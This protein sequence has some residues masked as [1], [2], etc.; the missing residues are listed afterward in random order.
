V[1][2]DLVTGLGRQWFL[3]NLVGFAVGGGIFGASQARWL[4]P[5]FEVVTDPATA[6]RIQALSSGIGVTLFGASV[7]FAEWL[8][9]RRRVPAAWW[10]PAT[11]LGFGLA[12]A[13]AGALSGLLGGTVTGMGPEHGIAGFVAAVIV[14][15]LALGLLPG[16]L[17]WM[18]LRRSSRRAGR[19]PWVTL[20]ALLAG[21]FGA[22]VI[23]RLG[24]A[25]VIRWLQPEDFPSA[26]ALTCA[27]LVIG[28]VYAV[29]TLSSLRRALKPAIPEPEA[30]VSRDVDQS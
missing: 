14:S 6:A 27:G 28:G 12:G 5:Y 9:L 10:A 19:W 11:M 3:A 18:I 26:K 20:A 13:G 4:R 2:S 16:T 17:Q 23:V 29:T 30:P 21:V 7:G 24:L 15:T 22:A 25:Y 1:A 8:V